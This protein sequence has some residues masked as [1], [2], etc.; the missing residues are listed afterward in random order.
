[1]EL[2]L[3]SIRPEGWLLQQLQLM[4]SGLTGHLDELYPSVLGSRNGWLGG[5]GDGWERGPYWLDGL[6][7]LAWI[8]DNVEMKAKAMPWIEWTLDSQTEDGYFGPVPFTEEPEPEPGIQKSPRRDWWPKMVMLKVLRQ[9]YD[10]TED[11]RVIDLMT[12]YFRYQLKALPETPLDNWSFWG[13]RRGGDNLMLVY[14]LYNKTGDKFLLELSELI[15][16]QTYPWTDIFLNETCYAGMDRKH[17]YPFN[18]ANSYPYDQ[19]LVENLCLKQLQ[20]F[21]CVNLAQGIKEPVIYYQQDPDPRYIEAVNR[22]FMD[23]REYHGQ[24]QGMYGGDEAL[25]GRI[26]TQGIEFCSITEL[27]FSLETMIGIT[28]D[29]DFMDH[30]EKIAYNALPTQASDDFTSRQ[31]FQ[32][33]NQVMLTRH[34]RNF[35]VE[36]GHGQTDLCYGLVTGYPCCTCNMHQGWPKFVQHLWYATPDGGFAA[37]MFAP[38]TMEAKV[39]DNVEV[40]IH[41]ETN[42]PFEDR[43]RF[44][45]ST[46]Q[47]VTF[48]FHIRIPGWC[49]EASISVNGKQNQIVEGGLMAEIKRDWSDG[50]MIEVNLPMHVTLSS[51]YEYAIAVERGPLVYALKIREDWKFV[52]NPD[53]WG[54][55]YEVRPTDPWNYALQESA[56]LDPENGFEFVSTASEDNYPWSIDAAPVAL[57]TKGIKIPDWKLYNEMAGPLPHRLRHKDPIN[58]TV[59]EITLIPY[60]CTTLRITE[61]PVVR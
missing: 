30:L 18:S 27:M 2:P 13:N 33:A 55:F 48:P 15:H 59:E 19:E 39:A 6:V 4:K 53:R 17:L 9:Y 52:E 51:W 35:F 49:R 11:S 22:A 37:V 26:P 36:D 16:E 54:D 32:Q 34:R 28:G 21:H 44:R 7:P 24:P 46:S 43:V 23:I 38:N 57:R 8:L 20:S 56:V 1:M 45:I 25:H 40:S 3:G 58:S 50:D 14:W 61:F 60:G 12:N 5:D 47:A 31:Y 29:V 10:A 41:E 42:Y